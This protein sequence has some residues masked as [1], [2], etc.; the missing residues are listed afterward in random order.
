MVLKAYTS[1]VK[2]FTAAMDRV[3]ETCR[4]VP[5]F[6]TFLRVSSFDFENDL[7]EFHFVLGVLLTLNSSL[8][9]CFGFLGK[10]WTTL[11]RHGFIL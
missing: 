4:T 2:N 3:K 9:P 7:L 1:Y 5:S 6:L 8:C 10:V 11:C